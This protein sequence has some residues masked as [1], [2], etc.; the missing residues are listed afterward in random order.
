MLTRLTDE[1]S[2]VVLTLLPTWFGPSLPRGAAR[3]GMPTGPVGIAEEAGARY[4]KG[5]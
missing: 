4:R 1:E 3:A 2:T 5:P